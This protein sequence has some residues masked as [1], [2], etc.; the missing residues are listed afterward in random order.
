[1]A[2]VLC[3]GFSESFICWRVFKGTLKAEAAERWASVSPAVGQTCWCSDGRQIPITPITP[4]INGPSFILTSS[5]CK[6]TSKPNT[7]VLMRLH[8][9]RVEIYN[10]FILYKLIYIIY[11]LYIMDIVCLKLVAHMERNTAMTHWNTKKRSPGTK[12]TVNTAHHQGYGY[13]KWL[14]SLLS[15]IICN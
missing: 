8:W 4:I 13:L 7:L 6:F 9:K 15:T 10:I 2:S 5:P 12:P 11:I 14:S 3:V 1:M